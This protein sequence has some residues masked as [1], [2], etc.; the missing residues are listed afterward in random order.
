MVYLAEDETRRA[1]ALK[2]ITPL[3]DATVAASFNQEVQS[4]TTIAHENVLRIIDHG[5][6]TL[7]DG[8][9][10]LFVVSE[11]CSGGDYRQRLQAHRTKPPDMLAITDD[12][13]QILAGLCALHTR[14]VHRDLKP[15]NVLIEGSIFKVADFGLARFVDAATRTHSFKGGGTPY[16]MAPEVWLMQRATPATDLY[17]V[18]VMLYEAFTGERP[19]TAADLNTLRDLHLYT[20]APRAKARNPNVS[21]IIDGII[22]KL[23]SKE[24]RGRYQSADEVLA[25]LSSV[26][27]SPT[28]SPLEDLARRMRRQ[29]DQAE[30]KQ[31]E[32]QRTANAAREIQARNQYMEKELLALADEV[33]DEINAHLVETKIEKSPQSNRRA[34][35]FGN[36]VLLIRFFP[37][38][39][40]YRNPI[41]PGRLQVLRNHH[42]VH[43]G[44]IEIQ[45]GAQDREGWNVILIRSED[46]V[47]GKWQLVETRLSALSRRSTP[48][49]PVATEANLLAD[50]LACHLGSVMHVFNLVNKDF[51]RADLVKIFGILIP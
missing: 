28:G 22:K 2:V 21:D 32:E 7:D 31:L 38:G 4:T 46:S 36:R 49:E 5:D 8:H 43:A 40:L 44:V 14:I 19:F 27:T 50:N 9:Q 39:E 6:F 24:P 29:H 45:E 12:F 48:Y 47:Y 11:Y 51:E 20:P 13:R 41:V 15:E 18:G 23:L 3:A 25:A 35:S 1:L 30:A 17:A 33:V 42:V 16:Y 37:E 34:Y 10:G 26:T